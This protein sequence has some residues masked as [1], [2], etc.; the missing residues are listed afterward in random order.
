MRAQPLFGDG[1]L[2]INRDFAFFKKAQ[3]ATLLYCLSGELSQLQRNSAQTKGL[4]QIEA[5]MGR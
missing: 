3:I 5:T 2:F 1:F 4:R